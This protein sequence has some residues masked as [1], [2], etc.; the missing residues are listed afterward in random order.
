MKEKYFELKAKQ[1]KRAEI[2][3]VLGIPEWKLKKIIA[4]E[5]WGKKAPVIGNPLAFSEFTENSSYWGG[6]LAADGCITGGF[7]KLM[8]NYDDTN[9]IEKFRD[10]IQSTHCISSNTDKYYRSEIGF[11]HPRIIEDLKS[12]FNI[13]TNKSLTY[14]LPK[15]IPDNMFNHYLRGYFDGDGCICESFSNKNSSTATLYTT[16][17]GS[18]SLISELSE[19]LQRLLNISGTVAQKEKHQILKYCTNSSKTLLNY[20]Y[21]SS[22]VFLDRKYALYYKIMVEHNRLTR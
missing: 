14:T 3:E 15:N 20:M 9:H 22:T 19:H 4:V 1:L 21:N 16:I 13:T 5:G 8:L 12:N 7:L 17:T 6:F 11:K 18:N 2:A 10:F